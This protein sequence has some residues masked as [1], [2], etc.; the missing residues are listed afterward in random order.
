[1]LGL[2]VMER[3]QLVQAELRKTDLFPFFTVDRSADTRN[4]LN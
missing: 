4:A 1:M 2:E 3:E